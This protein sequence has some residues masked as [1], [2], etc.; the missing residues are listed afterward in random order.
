MQPAGAAPAQGCQTPRFVLVRV[1]G[2]AED[3]QE[4]LRCVQGAAQAW[5]RGEAEDA[6]LAPQS[7]SGA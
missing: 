3:L 1:R 5:Q 4:L 2:C 7:H 6:T